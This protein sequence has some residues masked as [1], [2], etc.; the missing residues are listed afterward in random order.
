MQMHE[1]SFLDKQHRDGGE[2]SVIDTVT[3]DQTALAAELDRLASEH[4]R[5]AA[6]AARLSKLVRQLGRVGDALD[7]LRNGGL[8]TTSQAATICD[9]T[10]QAIRDWIEEAASR[11]EPIAEKRTTWIV[12]TPRLLAYVEKRCGGFPARVKAQNRLREHWPK[13]SQAPELRTGA[14]ERAAG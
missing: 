3:D 1:N 11:G 2:R 10:D 7:D 13:W 6:D 4:A 5:L 14:K 9:V 12:S 8:L